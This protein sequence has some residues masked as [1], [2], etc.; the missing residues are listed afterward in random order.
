MD[1]IFFVFLVGILIY[2]GIKNFNLIKRYKRNKQY[3]ESYKKV[4]HSEENCYDDLINYIEKE[5]SEEF[6]NKA[7]IIKLLYEIDNEI[8]TT[9]TIESIDYINLFCNKGVID[10][11]KTNLN[12]DCFLFIVLVI[13]KAYS[14]NKYDVIEKITNKFK[15]IEN[16]D[17]RLEYQLI[18]SLEDALIGSK[19][20]GCEFMKN[21]LEGEYTQYKYEKNMIGLYKRTAAAVLSYNN[22]E[23]DEYFK[24]ELHIFADTI[25]G[26]NLLKSLN[27]YEKY[28]TETVVEENIIQEDNK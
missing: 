28:K 26:E 14:K 9:Q 16:I 7:R 11:S 4:L 6:K 5:D 20:A 15:Q 17:G 21:M 2:I 23:F 10:H 12:S 27:V 1:K 24:N 13:T 8:D 19:V 3:I 18:I 25:I 22:E